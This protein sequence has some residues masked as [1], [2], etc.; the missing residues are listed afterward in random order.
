MKFN[1]KNGRLSLVQAV[2]I[3]LSF[4]IMQ[5]VWEY[6]KILTYQVRGS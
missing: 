1:V 6:A 3:L 4:S 2:F 5:F